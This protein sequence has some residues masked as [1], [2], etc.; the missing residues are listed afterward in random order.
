MGDCRAEEE[1]GTVLHESRA[2][3]IMLCWLRESVS[4]KGREPSKQA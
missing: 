4:K 2:V 3:L 1:M